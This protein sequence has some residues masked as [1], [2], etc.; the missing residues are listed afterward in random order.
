MPLPFPTAPFPTDEWSLRLRAAQLKRSPGEDMAFWVGKDVQVSARWISGPKGASLQHIDIAVTRGERWQ[1][2]RG[3]LETFAESRSAFPLAQVRER[4]AVLLEG[5]IPEVGTQV[6]IDS[7]SE[8]HTIFWLGAQETALGVIVGVRDAQGVQQEVALSRLRVLDA[9]AL[10]DAA[11]LA[12]APAQPVLHQ[13]KPA[14]IEHVTR[15]RSG[16]VRLSVKPAD[17]AALWCSPGDVTLLEGWT[18]MHSAALRDDASAI[19][20]LPR[21]MRDVCVT[22]PRDFGY[23]AS[24]VEKMD[25]NGMTPGGVASA[26][27]RLKALDS[28]FALGAALSDRDLA[29]LARK[30]GAEAAAWVVAHGLGAR[31]VALAV[32]S[33]T[34]EPIAFALEA[35]FNVDEK[36]LS[37]GTLRAT[38]SNPGFRAHFKK[39][40]LKSLDRATRDEPLHLIRPSPSSHAKC[41]ACRKKILTN[42]PQ[43]GLGEARDG[44]IR[45]DWFHV[46]C[47]RALHPGE[48]AEAERG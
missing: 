1:W 28:L 45:R 30:G 43:F 34:A 7:A 12:F 14:I 23:V 41:V 42:T 19:A 36:L 47:A 21:E 25:F 3:T 29:S 24:S 8:P 16:E 46:E 2:T 17:Q 44:A 4:L 38:L 27:A 39:Q 9:P 32:Q 5:A 48:V 10:S 33:R 35:G 11:L 20:A 15:G 40:D 22:Y 18:P 13:G 26:M 31:W 6:C 37:G